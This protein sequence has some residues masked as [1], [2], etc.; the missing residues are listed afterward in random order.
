MAPLP[1]H[2]KSAAKIQAQPGGGAL[3]I[4]ATPIGNLGDIT[5]RALD[6]LK[7]ADRI[8]CEDTRVT[9]KLAQHY[10]LTAPLV[11][12]HEHNEARM[13]VQ[14]VE[15]MQQGA[16]IAL[17]S[18]AGTPLLSD[19]GSRLVSAAIAANIPVIP[20]PGASALLAAL[21]IA[22]LPALPFH[23][24][25]FLPPKTKA[26]RDIFNKLATMQATLIFYESPNRLEDA[27]TDAT[28]TLGNRHAAVARELT[29]LHEEC[30]RGT[31]DELAQY[32]KEHP[33]KGECVLLIAGAGEAA[34][35]SEEEIDA[36]L[37]E[38]L[39]DHGVKEAA[40]IAAARTG[41]GKSDLYARALVL[42]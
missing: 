12:Y 41:L 1:I 39:I 21:T 38:L 16:R 31:L 4:V 7:S 29:K 8:A 34:P 32:Y 25:G 5:L 20:L 36:I 26:R 40:A 6:I 35:P 9:R 22:G 27:L 2:N 37:R 33:P 17:V 15:A 19:P 10:G 30:K 24:A 14:L 3:Y 28:A 23:F 11:A 42:K 18:D 13:S